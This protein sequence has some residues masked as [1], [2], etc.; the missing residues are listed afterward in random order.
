MGIMDGWFRRRPSDDEMREEIEAHV[1]MRAEHDGV[2]EAAAR[3]RLGN[4]LRTRESMRR[5]WIAEWWDVLRQ[6]AHSR[7]N[8]RSL[9]AFRSHRNPACVSSA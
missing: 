2:D 1:A 3:R 9:G 4:T 6:D 7:R 8:S 5:I